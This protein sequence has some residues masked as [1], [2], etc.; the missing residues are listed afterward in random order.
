M[1]QSQPGAGEVHVWGWDFPA[2]GS[3]L[4]A[5]IAL[6]D[7]VER[8]RFERLKS[9]AAAIQLAVSHAHLRR[10]LAGYLG[11]SPD[12]I[13]FRILDA[14]KPELQEEE[15]DRKLHFNLSH[16]ASVGLLAV[17]SHPVGVDVEQVRQIDHSVPE[18]YFSISELRDLKQLDGDAWLPGFFRCWTRKEA[19]LKAEGLGVGNRL[20]QFDVSLLP[21]VP[22]ALIATR[23]QGMKHWYL[24]DLHPRPDTIATLAVSVSNVKVS[25]F[26]V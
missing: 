23:V 17:S 6:L 11:I 19:I 8:Q 21:A 13:R 4:T 2:A 1:G 26:R 15:S 14:G 24:H 10:I 5:E 22:P 25:C 20:A 3:D 18:N 12:Y 7:E 9:P 16:T